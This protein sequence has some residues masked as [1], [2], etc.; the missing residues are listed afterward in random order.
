MSIKN[1]TLL[2][3]I[4]AV[5]ST[6]LASMLFQPAVDSREGQGSIELTASK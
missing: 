3:A 2:I 6:T 1:K 5:V 4:L